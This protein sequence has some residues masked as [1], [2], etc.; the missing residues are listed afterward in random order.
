MNNII[1]QKSDIANKKFTAIINNKKIHFGD[2]RYSDYTLTKDDKKK[3][4]YLARHK[5]DY[6]NNPNYAS[7]YSTNLLWNKPTLKESIKATNDKYNVNIK[8]K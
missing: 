1:I 8:L 4:A 6:F 7:F 5:H 3:K 2:S